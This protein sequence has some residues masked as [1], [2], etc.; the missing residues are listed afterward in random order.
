MSEKIFGIILCCAPVILLNVFY[1]LI[2]AQDNHKKPVTG[3]SR[4]KFGKSEVL[5]LLIPSS[6]E[7]LMMMMTWI[8]K[9][10]S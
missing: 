9:T 6:L 4:M 3:N 10:S 1:S 5:T 2:V 7:V 8:Y